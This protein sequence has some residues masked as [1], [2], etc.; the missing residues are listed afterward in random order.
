MQPRPSLLTA[1]PRGTT[2]P[3]SAAQLKKRRKEARA[4]L[5]EALLQTRAKLGLVLAQVARGRLRERGLVVLVFSGRRGAEDARRSGGQCA[6]R[7]WCPRPGRSGKRASGYPTKTRG[8]VK[9][10]STAPE[11]GGGRASAPGS[12][13]NGSYPTNFG[14]DRSSSRMRKPHRMDLWISS[15]N[16]SV[17]HGRWCRRAKVR[18]C[19][20][21]PIRHGLCL[22]MHK[23]VS[24][25]APWSTA[26]L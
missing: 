10:R 22:L 9:T 24:L 14:D 7:P 15:H 2:P 1:R 6:R 19:V 21:V 4:A 13:L 20:A 8:L 11:K 12:S 18:A 17:R 5:T 3:V 25:F 16:T 23:W 26:C